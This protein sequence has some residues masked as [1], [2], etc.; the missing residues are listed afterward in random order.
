[1]ND[2][3]EF[4]IRII[5]GSQI[6]LYMALYGGVGIG[7]DGSADL[8]V[9]KSINW[10]GTK[11]VT[12]NDN[13]VDYTISG[14]EFDWSESL[15]PLASVPVTRHPCAPRPRARRPRLLSPPQAALSSATPRELACRL[16]AAQPRREARRDT[17]DRRESVAPAQQVNRHHAGDGARRAFA[18]PTRERRS[19]WQAAPVRKAPGS[20]GVLLA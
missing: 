6:N 16:R 10:G 19:R 12:Y 20:P 5:F 8:Q 7:D 11:E 17:G 18:C 14:A 3:F 2:R 15:I 9:D 13:P 4:D 1:V